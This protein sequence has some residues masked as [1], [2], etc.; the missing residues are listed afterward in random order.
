MASYD[1]REEPGVA[2]RESVLTSPFPA[3][4]FNAASGRGRS[5]GAGEV[6]YSRSTTA[7]PRSLTT[8][9][10]AGL[11]LAS[12]IANIDSSGR[13]GARFRTDG[14]TFALMYIDAKETFATQVAAGPSRCV[15]MHLP[16]SLIDGEA[17]RIAERLR[18]MDATLIQRITP[19]IVDVAYRLCAPLPA[20]Y[21]EPARRLVLAARGLEL[22]A[23]AHAVLVGSK[24]R[25]PAGRQLRIARDATAYINENLSE[26]ISLAAL[27]RAVA[28][29]PRSLTEAFRTAH[30]E[31]IAAYVTRRR[32]ETAAAMLR[33]GQSISAVAFAVGYSPN[34]FSSAFR[35][36][37]GL[38]PR[39]FRSS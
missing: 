5:D 14:A 39:E 35:R 34:A 20:A 17:A 12:G 10:E 29:S 37:Y 15:G 18:Q 30:G 8:T 26:V 7:G 28:A 38:S 31:T 27:G 32:M 33:G 6:W 2:V 11:H 24:H 22:L 19:A 4:H 25:E 16:D 36:Y 13:S 3:T 9:V 21:G 1:I 23:A